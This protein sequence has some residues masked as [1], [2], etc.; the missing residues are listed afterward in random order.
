MEGNLFRDDESLAIRDE[1]LRYVS[2]WPYLLVLML[3]FIS[4]AYFYVRYASFKYE[5]SAI[6]EILDESQDSEMALPTALTVFNRSMI[7]LENEIN[8]L[9]SFSLHSEVVEKLN[10][11]VLFY[12]VGK[13]KTSQKTKDDWFDDYEIK[14][15]IDTDDIKETL[16]YEI[17]LNENNSFSVSQY[18]SYNNFIKKF[19]F[20][21]LSTKNTKNDLP[22]ELNIFKDSNFSDI[23]KLVLAPSGIV[24]NQFRKKIDVLPLGE[25]SDQLLIKLTDENNEISKN[26][27]NQLLIAF[28]NDGI[29][30]RQLEYSSTIEFVNQREKILKKELE[31][32]ELNKQNFKKINNLTDISVDAGNNIEL[33]LSYDSEL[34]N[35]ESQKT[36]AE[37]LLENLSSIEYTYLPLNIGLT[38]FEINS[39][40]QEYNSVISQRNRLLIEAGPNNSLI[41]ALNSQLDSIIRNIS[42]SIESYINS[43][44]I[45]IQNLKNK[46]IEFQT[47]YNNIPKNE[48]RLRS[49]ERELTIKEA[50]YLL[51]LQKREEAAINL[52]VIKPTIKVIDYPITNQTAISPNPFLIYLGSIVF[53][54]ILFIGVLYTRFFLD[55]KIH[56]KEQLVKKLNSDIPIISEVPYIKNIDDLLTSKSSRSLMSEAIRM[57]ISNLRFTSPKFNNAESQIIVFTSSIKGEGK[58][59]ASVN[60]AIGL[61]NDLKMD[62]KVIL[63]GTDLRN[64]QV[65]KNFG[66]DKSQAGVSEII[67]KNDIDS[68]MDYINRF[69]NLDVLFSG[70]IP[71]NPTA[72]LSSDSFKD[73]LLKLKDNYDYIIVDSAPCILVSDTFQYLDLADSIIYLFRANYTPSKI[74]DFI[75]ELYLNKKINNINIVLNSGGSSDAYGYKYGYQYGYKYGYKYSYNY[76]YGYG[77]GSDK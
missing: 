13:I 44:D 9:N 35:S 6:I 34:F 1:I 51:L 32:I 75:N 76:G 77:Y 49:I 53:S 62:K 10:S 28:D 3:F 39:I 42:E 67:Y 8:V 73:L 22:F 64:P 14:F 48:K 63:V 52:A 43:I 25:D 65:H 27:L 61:A 24:V 7:N 17:D 21:T 40:I 19:E 72:L 70:S 69:D 54:I 15:K 20:K 41:K 45:K 26:Y 33:K 71:P 5:T 18:D 38:D 56:T 55:N 37:Y 12:G 68:Y 57:L 16:I 36:L 29:S 58:T 46:E 47:A 74:T 30:D 31:V 59:L 4:A 50:L 66:I 11:N 23:R 60:T 2:F